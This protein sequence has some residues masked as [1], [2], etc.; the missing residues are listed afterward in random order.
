MP[1]PLAPLVEFINRREAEGLHKA[2]REVDDWYGAS[3]HQAF[4]E[5]LDAISGVERDAEGEYHEFVLPFSEHLARR[6][7][8]LVSRVEANVRVHVQALPTQ[9][10]VATWL[11]RAEEEVQHL[12]DTVPEGSYQ[13]QQRAMLRRVLKGL[14]SRRSSLSGRTG[15]RRA[16]RPP[17]DPAQEELIR[18]AVLELLADP[19][20]RHGAGR[21]EGRINL[22]WVISQ[23]HLRDLGTHLQEKQLGRKI[24][25]AAGDGAG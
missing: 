17:K 24:K 3:G 14:R 11:S 20:S 22:K 10:D 9:A 18:D 23:L 2:F 5:E 8:E 7:E 16:G 15:Q 21:W 13:D 4:D 6:I 12:S 25:K 19:R 1:D